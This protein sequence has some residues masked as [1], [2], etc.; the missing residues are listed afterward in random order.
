M[1]TVIYENAK[2]LNLLVLVSR[3][4]EKIERIFKDYEEEGCFVNKDQCMKVRIEN[5][6]VTFVDLQFDMGYTYNCHTLAISQFDSYDGH[7]F[8]VS[9][10]ETPEEFEIELTKMFDSFLKRD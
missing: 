9:H 5:G 8:S 10:C 1:K 7:M 6:M 4:S 3:L 2:Y